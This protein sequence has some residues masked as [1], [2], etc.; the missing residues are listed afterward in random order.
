MSCCEAFHT[1]KGLSE[2]AASKYCT[3]QGCKV[4]LPCP[5]GR[6]LF[7][8]A[9]KEGLGE[10]STVEEAALLLKRTASASL[11]VQPRQPSRASAL[12]VLPA[13]SSFRAC[14]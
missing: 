13:C 3:L 10:R 7:R 1:H 12:W 9:G 11:C 4:T 5:P 14:M 2:T 8:T 6:A